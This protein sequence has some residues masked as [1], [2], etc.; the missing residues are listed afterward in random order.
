MFYWYQVKEILILAIVKLFSSPGNFGQRDRLNFK[1]FHMI[2]N[3]FNFI[4]NQS[5]N[6]IIGK[7]NTFEPVVS[8][9]LNSK[10]RYP[11]GFIFTNICILLG[12]LLIISFFIYNRNLKIIPLKSL[13]RYDTMLF[14]ESPDAHEE[15]GACER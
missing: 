3:I 10:T 5:A 4:S 7:S 1:F 9:S 8:Q 11:R 6:F 2:K 14:E 12:Q 15:W 13:E